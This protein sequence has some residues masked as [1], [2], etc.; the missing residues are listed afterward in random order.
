MTARDAVRQVRSRIE[1]RPEPAAGFGPIVGSRPNSIDRAPLDYAV[2]CVDPIEE[3]P[4]RL[5]APALFGTCE[6]ILLGS[7]LLLGA[8][9]V[10]FGLSTGAC[11]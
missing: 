2:G 9:A 3:Q 5:V 4:E 8:G 6:Y 7:I 1:R 10:W 11:G